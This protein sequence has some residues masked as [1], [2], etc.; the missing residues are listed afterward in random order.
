MND[1][2][3][4]LLALPEQ[5][6]SVAYELDVLHYIVIG[7]SML[8]AV[9]VAGAVIVFLLRFHRGARYTPARRARRLPL[10]AEVVAISGLLAMFLAFWV[11]GFRQFVHLQT[12]PAGAID[13]Y[14]V[15]KQWMWT[16]AYP[17]GT[18][19]I[20]DLYVPARRPVRLILTSRDVIHSFFV[21]QFRIKQDV[22]P[23]RSTQAWFEVTEPGTYNVFCTEYCGTEHSTM[24]ARVIALGDADWSRW[25]DATP[26]PPGDLASAGAKIAAERGC[27]RCHTVDGTPHLG[28]TW[29]GVY[30]S[31]VELAGGARVRVDESYLTESMMDPERRIRAG[32]A[33]IMPTYRGMIDA[34]E[35]AALV[36]LIRSLPA[37]PA[38]QSPPPT[39]PWPASPVVEGP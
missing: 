13:V 3:R 1:V 28:P 35:V 14:V 23:G 12:P 29:A 17:N 34:V 5:A 31:T 4:W 38:A 9:G 39:G 25:A 32:Y 37:A 15:A 27:L 21:P 2:L 11:V 10:W 22:V 6:S 8:G 24:R 19:T 26:R 36:E 18:S 30:G 20:G 7:I 33:P 16:F